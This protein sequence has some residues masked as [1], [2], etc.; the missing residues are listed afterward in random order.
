MLF[1][2]PESHRLCKKGLATS[3]QPK[4]RKSLT[5]G[6]FLLYHNA[7]FNGIIPS[8]P[9]SALLGVS[10]PALNGISYIG[11]SR[12]KGSFSNHRA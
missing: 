12:V 11:V 6:I 8:K 3:S 4:A 2:I 10:L 7:L 5:A 1:F 9:P